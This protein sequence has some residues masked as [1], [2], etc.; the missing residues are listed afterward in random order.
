MPSIFIWKAPIANTSKSTIKLY[1]GL[2]WTLEENNNNSYSYKIDE[3]VTTN[4]N[5]ITLLTR[6]IINMPTNWV[7]NQLLEV[8]EVPYNVIKSDNY[9]HLEH[10]GNWYRCSLT[11]PIELN[12]TNISHEFNKVQTWI[13]KKNNTQTKY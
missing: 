11:S 5:N 2:N 6:N 9:A 4:I 12:L 1:S 13:S 3:Q 10:I 8:F 7:G